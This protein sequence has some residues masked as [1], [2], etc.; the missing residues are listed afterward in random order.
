M[1]DMEYLVAGLGPEKL[2]G[3]SCRIVLIH[4]QGTNAATVGS[5]H[6]VP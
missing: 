5:I 3:A 2:Q 4:V 6:M 1:I